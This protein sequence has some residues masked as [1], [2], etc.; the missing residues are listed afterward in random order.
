MQDRTPASF[1][2][3]SCREMPR[4]VPALEYDDEVVVRRVS[5]QG[6]FRMRGQ[7]TF[8][9]E[10]FAYEYIALRAVD[11]RY[12]QVLYGPVPLGYLDSFRHAFHR[13]LSPA[14]RHRL[15]LNL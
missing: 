10:I 7:R 9:S 13:V 15:G 12:F 4:R 5:Q 8:L 2:T 1:Y 6:S 14:L 3:A 11:E